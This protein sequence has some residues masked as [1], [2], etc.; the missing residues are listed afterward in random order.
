[1]DIFII[2]GLPSKN[3]S[4][5]YYNFWGEGDRFGATPDSAQV[6]FLLSA[7]GHTYL[8]QFSEVNVEQGLNPDLLHAKAFIADCLLRLMYLKLCLT[9]NSN[10]NL[11]LLV[12]TSRTYIK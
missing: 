6:L 4:V 12:L 8:D 2:L 3:N 7:L 10:L 5:F 1:M 9:N 11:V